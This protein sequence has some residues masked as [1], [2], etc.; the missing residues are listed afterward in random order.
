MNIGFRCMALALLLL[1]QAPFTNA[2]SFFGTPNDQYRQSVALSKAFKQWEVYSLD[3]SGILSSVK[4]NQPTDVTLGEHRWK[5]DLTPAHILSSNYTLQL[6]TPQGKELHKQVED[7][8][9]QGYET[10]EGGQVRLT[11]ASNFIYGFVEESADT[12]YIEPLGYYEPNAGADL[13][14]VY[15]DKAVIPH[16]N[17]VCLSLERDKK[18]SELEHRAPPEDTPETISACYELELAIAS[19]RSM[20][21][22][23][24][25]T[26]A[27]Q[28]HNIG[29]INTVQTNY[30]GVFNHDI[31]YVI[32]TQLV[33]T[34]TDPWSSTTD[35]G[36]FLDEFVLWGENGGFGGIDYDLG[37]IWTNRNFD[38]GT[39]GIAYVDAVCS[40]LR[41]HALQDF[42]SNA[43]QL[44]CMTAHEIG[45]NFG[46]FH[47]PENGSSC[48]PNYIMCPFVSTT[49]TW[50]NNSKNQ[51]NS[52]L[53]FLI[54]SGCLSPCASG[55]AVSANFNWSPNP[56]CQ[57]QAV[58]FTD[59]STGTITGR[60]WTF[61][62]GSP[63]TST[64][65][66]PSVTWATAGTYNVT[67]TVS[68][69]GGPSTVTKQVVI[70]PKPTANF[71]FSVSGNTVTFTNTSTNANTYLWNFGNGFTSTETDPQFTYPTS[72]TYNV[73]LTAT[74]SCGTS[75][76]TLPVK[77]APTAAFN[78]NI[79]NGCTPL[80]VQFVSQSS[81]SAITGYNWQF[82]GGTPSTSSIANPVVVYSSAGEYDVT[83]T[84]TNSAGSSS[85]TQE[86]FIVTQSGP[87]AS[88]T[89]QINN[90]TVQFTNT[91]TGGSTYS[92]DFGDGMS[93]TQVSPSHTYATGNLYT[94]TLTVT[95]P[96]GTKTFTRSIQLEQGPT[97][98][99][100]ADVTSGCAPLTV[101]F[102]NQSSANADTYL[103]AFPGG[104]PSSSTEAN[105]TVVYNE[106]GVYDVTLTATNEA[107]ST[108]LTQSNYIVVSGP[109]NA[110]FNNSTSLLTATFSNT[111]QNATT[112]SWNFGDGSPIVS[113]AQPVHT[114][115]IDG[116]YTV[117]LTASNNCGSTTIT[118]TVTV[119]SLP[120]ANFNATNNTGCA[121]LTVTFHNQS[122]I[123]ATSYQWTF[124]GGNPAASTEANPTVV[125]SSAGT[126]SATL[127][128]GNAAGFDTLVQNNVVVVN[129]VPSAGFTVSTNGATIS[130]NNQS[131]NA[132][133]YSW[134]FG[135]GTAPSMQTSPAHTYLSDGTYTITLTATNTCGSNTF[136]QV[137]VI[138][139]PP[140]AAFGAGQSS[141]CSP[142]T[143]AFTNQS[144]TNATSFQ[145]LF[146]GGSPS[147]ST[148]TNPTVV[149][150][151]P[152]VYSVTLIA[153]NS[154]GADTTLQSGVVVV[155]GAPTAEFTF[156]SNNLTTTFSNAS[157]NATSY[158]WNFGDGSPASTQAGPTHT[159]AADGSYLVTLTASNACGSHV[160]THIIVVTSPPTAA[161]SAAQTSGCGP[162]TVAFT[163]Q[164]SS[165]AT[166]FQ[167]SFPG[168][169]PASSIL[170]N[171]TVMYNAPGTYT[172]MLTASNAAGAHVVSQTG[173]ITILPLPTAFFEPH[174]AGAGVAFT[175][176]SQ[177]GQSYFWNF[178]DPGSAN[179]T[180]TEAEP[181][182]Q[183]SQD[184]D[185]TVTLTV[186][187]N[188]GASS[189]S[190]IV[191]IATPPTASYHIASSGP[192]C[193]PVSIQFESTSSDNTT[194]YEWVFEGGSPASSSDKDPQVTWSE[195][196]TYVVSLT[197]MNATGSSTYSDTIE[198]NGLPVAEFSGQ[199][200]GL[201]LILSN[202]SSG[203]DTYLWDF[204]DP[205]S[206]AENFSM[207][208]S[209]THS[210]DSTGTYF[211]QLTAQN[212]CGLDTFLLQ[213]TIEGDAPIAAFNSGGTSTFCVPATVQ[214]TDASF[215]NPDTWFWEFPGGDPATSTEQ[216]PAVTYSEPGAYTVTLTSGNVYGTDVVSQEQAIVVAI[217]P[218]AL[219]G[220]AGLDNTI[221]FSNASTGADSYVWHF[222]DGDTSTLAAPEHVFTASGTYEIVLIATNEC[223]SDTFSR[224]IE[225]TI[226]GTQSAADWD[227][228]RVFPNPN[229]GR[230][231]VE[232]S[233]LPQNE[234]TFALFNTLGQQLL[235]ETQDFRSGYLFHTFEYSELP[236]AMYTLRI[237]AGGQS[238]YVKLA[239]QR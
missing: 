233:G 179:N 168:G 219:F 25:T 112:Y 174:V 175:N 3:A 125:Y 161:F 218:V 135:D 199:T 32:V 88:F 84:V 93:S 68:G 223:G 124:P 23:Y 63:A 99:F 70:A 163:N 146:P 12:Y 121:S 237:S 150:A 98:G 231:T 230:F 59:A 228:F 181:A 100:S 184:G 110:A 189:L 45:H 204:G 77:T 133:A 215:G 221:L 80:S 76:K 47:D 42:T 201:S 144:T 198:V 73:T 61:Q 66:N 194:S 129:T 91:S 26:T 212:E 14:V 232:L 238:R 89:S 185:Y 127:V 195:P 9:Y 36:N 52:N 96:C 138:T 130:V 177:N 46:C 148:E 24:I 109:P 18:R 74:N 37:E 178:G 192:L 114:Y 167:W 64:A 119:V 176:G 65:T 53:P 87:T 193:S 72:G 120:Q 217:P 213:V 81:G 113:D 172:V 55:P 111:T 214:F 132:T 196:G 216:N 236:A 226:T 6:I 16:E 134:N 188:C 97:P 107:G 169:S 78:A 38:G 71:T 102:S 210:F 75:T 50:S 225:L 186:M 147:S 101:T 200:A 229:P 13:F 187:N 44:R 154:A 115:A 180:S 58:Q 206:G 123:N 224:V 139:T 155:N 143:V 57:S 10:R 209:P 41:Y 197:A 173:Y 95:N 90:L 17:A 158:S 28:N 56:A 153:S 142:H 103:W 29:V 104:T 60:S 43:Q 15:A 137:V 239:V 5:L 203:A 208:V 67:L 2:Q 202:L 145:W 205:G 116:T 118:H 165:N 128:T 20:F 106:A 92:W 234:L 62:G 140:V 170:P 122:S 4:S 31:Q 54:S 136:T 49:N 108:P 30:T 220:Y 191:H 94:V 211:V 19:D 8:S 157:V 39:I 1:F 156:S 83:L 85:L 227:V 222:G 151:V 35:A 27:V 164:S 207:E 162:L 160:I 86:S 22:K 82:P 34:G 69:S 40:N 152:G 235:F 33:I 117:T 126:Y 171:P 141:G 48:P 11:L 131:V 159:F 51:V 79:R 149:Y 182:H 166:S 105:P 21:N 190:Q 7:P 183:Y